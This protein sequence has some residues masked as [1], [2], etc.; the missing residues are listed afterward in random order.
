MHIDTILRLVP[1]PDFPERRRQCRRIRVLEV[2]GRSILPE[3]LKWQKSSPGVWKAIVKKLELIAGEMTLPRLD[4]VKRVGQEKT[5][6][7]VV[8]RFRATLWFRG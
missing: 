4:T 2:D 1:V 7:E 3:L 8:A 5:I 6:I